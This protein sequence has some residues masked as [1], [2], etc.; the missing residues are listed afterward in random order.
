MEWI[1]AIFVPQPYASLFLVI[2][3]PFHYEN[4]FRNLLGWVSI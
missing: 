2:W 3:G 4:D 1:N